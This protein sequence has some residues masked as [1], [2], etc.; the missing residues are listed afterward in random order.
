M[1]HRKLFF[2]LAWL[3]AFLCSLSFSATVVV[4][5]DGAGGAYTTIQE[6]VAVSA[7]GEDTIEIQQFTVPFEFPGG[8]DLSW[9]SLICT[10]PERATLHVTGGGSLQ[11]THRTLKN[12]KFVGDNDNTTD[13]WGIVAYGN[14]T[15]ENCYVTGVKSAAIVLRDG[16]GEG[17]GITTGATIRDTYVIGPKY[18][19]ILIRTEAFAENGPILINH[20]TLKSNGE[21]FPIH[22]VLDPSQ[23]GHDFANLTVRNT[24]MTNTPRCVVAEQ[25]TSLAYQHS[26][27][28]YDT[29]WVRDFWHW[30]GETSTYDTN[31]PLGIGDVE[32]VPP[33]FTNPDA[34][35]YSLLPTSKLLKA[36]D[37]GG[38]IGAWQGGGYPIGDVIVRQDGQGGAYTTLQEAILVTQP[39]QMIEIQQHTAPFVFVDGESVNL[40]NLSIICSTSRPA[41]ITFLNAYGIE[42]ADK[43]TLQN[44]HLIG[45]REGWQ[46]GIK[47]GTG[48]IFKNLIID[49]FD[50]QGIWWLHTT[51]N[52]MSGL[53]SHCVLIDNKINFGTYDGSTNVG[54]VLLDHCTLYSAQDG[55]PN[56]NFEDTFPNAGL[57]GSNLEIKNSILRCSKF[58]NIIGYNI[59]DLVYSHSYND[60]I[61]EWVREVWGQGS[62]GPLPPGPG[63]LEN[64]DPLF[65]NPAAG[66][67]TLQ[68][69]S[70]VATTAEG[71]T[72]MGA[73][74]VTPAGVD[75]WSLY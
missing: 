10:A 28:D 54:K 5:Q 49:S 6:A 11:I 55:K 70:P 39:G 41:V 58:T 50:E 18:E 19:C 45:N 29:G 24:V 74:P 52:P 47:C 23:I 36:A 57:D 42:N 4:R 2:F 63:D 61:H 1:N 27:N 65:T 15:I 64:V 20:C 32:K 44:L 9:R 68:G 38:N 71:G 66:D 8:L 26:F 22:M 31:T 35:D 48:L 75:D 34:G 25:P 14:V 37:D 73:Y 69:S 12:I 16:A 43:V 3:P 72:T 7:N 53:L 60:Y 13:Q 17:G 40:S 46:T 59:P 51:G 67:L 33:A 21:G 62:L 30:D 56:I